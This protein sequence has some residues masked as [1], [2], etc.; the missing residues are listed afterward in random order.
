M[1]VEVDLPND[2]LSLYP[3]M[4]TT[5]SLTVSRTD[6]MPRVPDDALVFRSG[7]V[8]APLVRENHLYLAPVT[9]GW[10]SGTEAEITH[11]VSPGDV[12]AVNVGQGAE[13][14]EP[15]QPVEMTS[16]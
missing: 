13:D 11:G 4:Y 9:L 10:D 7:K 2:D 6:Q 16:R 1:R 15:V 12:V 5:V 8:Y 3:G 14:G